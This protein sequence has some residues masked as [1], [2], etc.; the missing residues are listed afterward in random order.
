MREVRWGAVALL[1][2]LLSACGEDAEQRERPPAAPAMQ[3]GN[4]T[5][6]GADRPDLYEDD[7]G[8]E[9]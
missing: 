2:L 6:E 8:T 1:G 7:A 9:R 5:A 4:P 3:P